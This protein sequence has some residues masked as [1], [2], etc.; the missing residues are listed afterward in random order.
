MDQTKLNTLALDVKNMLLDDKDFLYVT[1]YK[2][3][4][5]ENTLSDNSWLTLF[6]VINNP[7]IPDDTTAEDLSHYII[8][9]LTGSVAVDLYLKHLVSSHSTFDIQDRKGYVDK[10]YFRPDK[11]AV[12][13]PGSTNITFKL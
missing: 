11:P 4:W 12:I 2:Y 7:D 8:A 3:S 1:K 13:Q 9:V 5:I 10:I 6:T